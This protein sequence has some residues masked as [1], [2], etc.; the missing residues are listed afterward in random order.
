MCCF[1][2]EKK[3][4]KREKFEMILAIEEVANNEL[5]A[6]TIKHEIELLDKKR[7][8]SSTKL[9]AK[10]TENEEI[11]NVIVSI[12]EKSGS[13]MTVTQLMKT[14][15]LCD[16]SMNK[17]TALVT[18][19]KKEHRIFRFVEKRV[20]YFRIPTEEDVFED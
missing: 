15:E 4:T 6:N 14:E 18:Q 2:T 8:S 19:L 10:Q 7:T 1:M 11:K 9:T 17:L 13:A 12:L 5:L 20:T 16:H 3:L